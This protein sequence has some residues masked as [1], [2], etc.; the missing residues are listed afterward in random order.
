MGNRHSSNPTLTHNS[1]RVRESERER[2]ID[3][4]KK[5]ERGSVERLTK[6]GGRG[7]RRDSE[8]GGLKSEL[9]ERCRQGLEWRDGWRDERKSRRWGGSAGR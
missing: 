6:R 7:E 3:R 2:A 5:R 9:K 8:R 1:P 4:K